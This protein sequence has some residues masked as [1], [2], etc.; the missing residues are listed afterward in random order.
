MILIEQCKCEGPLDAKKREREHIEQLKA[1]LNKTVPSRTQKEWR[2][3]N[4]YKKKR[5]MCLVKT[6]TIDE[7]RS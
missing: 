5:R 4:K 6:E 3:E 1:S 2:E 7:G